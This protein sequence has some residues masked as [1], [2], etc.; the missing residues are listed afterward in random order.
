MNSISRKVDTTDELKNGSFGAFK[1]RQ[2]TIPY[3]GFESAY[4]GQNSPG[5]SFYGDVRGSSKVQESLSMTR[6]SQKY[7]MPKNQ[8][9]HELTKMNGPSPAAYQNTN[10]VASKTTLRKNGA[11]SMPK[12]ERKFDFAKFSNLHSN[13]VSK[14]YYWDKNNCCKYCY[15]ISFFSF[16]F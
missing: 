13:L 10:E 12:Q 3:K 16:N 1:D 5:P 4:L 14:G 15:I 11:F 7:S 2:R 9:F 8:R 6:A